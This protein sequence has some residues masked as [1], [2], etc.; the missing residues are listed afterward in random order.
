MPELVATPAYHIFTAGG[1]IINAGG[2]QFRHNNQLDNESEVI[3]LKA[4]YIMGDHLLTFGYE[5]EE[6]KTANTFVPFTRAQYLVFGGLDA[7]ENREWGLT[8][9]GN[10]TT[11]VVSD[12]VGRFTLTTNSLFVQDEWAVRDDLTLK[13]G[14]RFE[15]NNN[16]SPIPHNPAFTERNGFSNTN[17]LDGNDLVLPRFGF[18]WAVND[19][20]T[21]RGGA[22][23]FGGGEPLIMLANSYARNAIT[24]NIVCV[25]CIVAAFGIYGDIAAGLHDP[26]SAFNLLQQFNGIDPQ[27]AVEAIHPDWETLST[28][29]YSLGVDFEVG[30][31]WDMSAEVIFSDVKDGFNVTEAR[32]SV[33][34]SGP[35]G[36]PIY[37]LPYDGDYILVNTGQGSGTVISFGVAKSWDT[38]N[39]RFDATFGY[40][41]TDVEEVRAYNRFITY[42]SFAFDATTD[43]NNMGL[44]PSKYEIEDKLSATFNWENEIWGDNTTRASLVYTGRS[45]R[46]F[47]YVMGNVGMAFGGTSL[48][49]FG[50]EGDNPGSQLFYVPTGMNDPLVTGDGKF[51][52]D[53]HHFIE[54]DSCLAG[55]R[56][57]T[58]GRN[59]CET[60]FTNIWS[61][62]LMQEISFGDGKKLELIMDIENLLNLFNSDWGRVDSY[63]APSNVP[64]ANVA[65][66]ADGSQYIYSATSSAV[67]GP[68]TIV[69]KPAIALIPSAYRIQ[70]GVR[71]SF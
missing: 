59:N 7:L 5:S 48:A 66:S 1:G 52:S 50:S 47:S 39:G 34:G 64:V 38:D 57:R 13:F 46:H 11:G 41:N 53:L 45:G 9:Y 8:L 29:K 65:I 58:V 12:A 63:T 2:D 62:R 4:D 19:R 20:M 16:S 14:V 44:S 25:P 18:N 56:G 40:T 36:R 61:L 35:D 21:V 71:F 68:D 67:A 54:G 31:G 17:N 32:R 3:R 26:N 22:G 28:W 42:E 6:K 27:A 23:L 30:N 49:D 60:G 10:S 51:L 69:P 24:R 15:E 43:Y 70:L 37:D 33:V 55:A